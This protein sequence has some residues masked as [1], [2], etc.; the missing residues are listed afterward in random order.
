[1]IR[2]PPSNG[3]G[4]WDGRRMVEPAM[5]YRHSRIRST[6]EQNSVY[7]CPTVGSSLTSKASH[8]GIV[9]SPFTY[10]AISSTVLFKHSKT[11]WDSNCSSPSFVNNTGRICNKP[12]VRLCRRLLQY[13]DLFS[14][15]VKPT[16]DTSTDL[17]Q[18]LTYSVYQLRGAHSHHHTTHSLTHSPDP[19]WW[20]CPTQDHTTLQHYEPVNKIRT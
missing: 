3:W 19:V 2:V 16:F 4:E 7:G 9:W 10:S 5:S 18:Q 11:S 15:R 13:S 20:D 8:S 1:M 14:V 12:S 17:K 6:R